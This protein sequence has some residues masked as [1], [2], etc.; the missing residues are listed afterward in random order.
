MSILIDKD[1]ILK[2]DKAGPR[3][4]SYP[5]APTWSDEVN[6]SVYI[7]KLKSFGQTDKTLS[8]YIHIP[9]CQTL[10]TYCGCNVVIRPQKEK[11]GD[12]YL[13]HLIREME[14][15]AKHIGTKKTVHQYHWGGGTPTFL[16][17]SQIERLF[18]KTQ[19]YFTLSPTSEIAIEVDPRTTDKAKIRSLRRLGFNRI[20]FGVQDFDANVQEKVNR[21][22]PLDLV[23]DV[24][25]YCRELKFNSINFDLIYGLPGQTAK[26]FS[27]TIKQVIDLRPDRIALY[28]YAHVPWLKKHQNKM[29][30]ADLPS[31]DQK[32]DIFLLAREQFLQAGYQAIAMDHF[33]LNDDELAK[34]FNH[35]EL[36]RN[37]MGYTVQPAD[38]YIGLG[39]TSIGFLENTFVHNIKVLPEYYKVLD[40]GKL[41]VERGKIL[42]H[43][44]TVRRWTIN[45]L[46]CQFQLD[47]VNFQTIF[48]TSFDIYFE[49]EQ[50]HL[51]HCQ[52]EGLLEEVGSTLKVT[53]I[54]KI[55][56]RNICMGFDAYLQKKATP[57]QRFSRTI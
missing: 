3:Y 37:F 54:G 5:T 2:Y 57:Q 16:T 7:E 28:S 14:L 30:T 25:A 31:A 38:E 52:E 20:S 36:Y 10:C 47:K 45:V 9:F 41:P 22:Q 11:Y 44:D 24:H 1:T 50:K 15:I 55:F 18:T 26:G 42:T 53:E 51:K 39:L 13:D 46:M 12:V 8:L 27:E 4:T 17:E 49:N 29:N 6:E 34:A 21:I 19:E 32:L 56:I 48:G 40:E 23:A 35:G 33:A 43:D